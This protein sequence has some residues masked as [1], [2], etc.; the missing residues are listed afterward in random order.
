MNKIDMQRHGEW[1]IPK[2]QDRFGG[3][4]VQTVNGWIRNWTNSNEYNLACT[5][6]A[7]S[8][9]IATHDLANYD[10][11]IEEVFTFSHDGFRSDEITLF[12]HFIQWGK[13][14][15]AS[16]FR[17]FRADFRFDKANEDR[18]NFYKAEMTGL[19]SRIT[20]YMAL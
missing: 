2:V 16:E 1:L 4:S 17:F 19:K 20:C 5:D 12:R 6:H 18:R 13:G 7:V 11:V 8:L 9:A 14:I 15:H 3:P 10:S